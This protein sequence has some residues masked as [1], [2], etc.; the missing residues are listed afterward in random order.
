MNAS[1][2]AD[3]QSQGPGQDS[4][5]SITSG[6]SEHIIALQHVGHIVAD[7]DVAINSYRRLYGLGD[8]SVRRIPDQGKDTLTRFAF[9]DV[10]GTE[11]ELIEPVS[12]A[13]KNLLFAAPSGGG[14]I[15]H[16]AWRVRK[17]DQA[18][19]ELAKC[20]ITAGFVT[21]NGPVDLPDKRMVYLDP[22]TT[23]GILIELLEFHADADA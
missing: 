6:L 9:L 2:P 19:A 17:M 12:E 22:A 15:N 4:G 21:P 23:D 13:F 18:L 20:G 1:K 8:E 7:L 10:A 11:F 16:L 14:G 3:S 5:E